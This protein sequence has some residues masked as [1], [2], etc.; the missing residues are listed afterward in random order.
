MAI[1]PKK[2]LIIDYEVIYG[3]KPPIDIHE[4]IQDYN[5]NEVINCTV[6]AF[7]LYAFTSNCKK[8]SQAFIFRLYDRKK[9]CLNI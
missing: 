8:L 4:L 7:T 5:I 6:S 2:T 9:Y 3:K 1:I